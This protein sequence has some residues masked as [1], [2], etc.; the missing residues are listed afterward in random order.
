MTD[1]TFPVSGSMDINFRHP[2]CQQMATMRHLVYLWCQ[3][4]ISVNCPVK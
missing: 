4:M 2:T 1:L 3:G